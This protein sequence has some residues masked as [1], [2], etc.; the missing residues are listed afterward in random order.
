MNDSQVTEEDASMEAEG[1]M[2]FHEST[3]NAFSAGE[4]PDGSEDGEVKRE[5]ATL[6]ERQLV[7]ASISRN[8]ESQGM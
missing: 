5:E 2:D 8:F 7:A 3:S 4:A 1:E 6:L